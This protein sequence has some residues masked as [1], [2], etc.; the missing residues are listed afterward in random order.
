MTEKVYLG[1]LNTF[2]IEAWGAALTV[3]DTEAAA[4]AVFT[5]ESTHPF[6]I[7]GGGS[8]VLFTNTELPY[9][10]IKNEIKGIEIIAETASEMV[11]AVGGGEIWHD[12]VLWAVQH[13]LGGIENLAL[14]P[15][16]VGAAPIQNIGAYGV[17]IKDVF[18]SLTAIDRQTGELLTFNAVDCA[19]GYRDSFFKKEGKDRFF[20]SKVCFT[21]KKAPHTLHM[22]YGDIRH[23]LQVKNIEN[24]DIQ[25]IAEAVMAIRQS[26]LPDPSVLG[27]AGSFFKNPEIDSAQFETL[28]QE[29]PNIV[30]YP[31]AQGIKLAAGWLIEQAGLKGQRFG[32]VGVHERQ[33][34]V[35]V[36]YGGGS[37]RDIKA[38]A[39]R[40]QAKVL[41]K[42]GVA[43]TPEVSCVA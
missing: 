41:E 39:E 30:G 24:P 29:F 1:G 25:D 20:I 2:G 38:L 33:A 14:I 7:L 43:L 8:N 9:H 21:L 3:V 10:F 6:Y 23:I 36:H 4:Q 27:N 42:F 15:G 40:V 5:H 35:L 37:G 31:T 16:T 22:N 11:V 13:Q 19:F 28:K 17:E 26:K 32:A 18:H 34:L 12:F